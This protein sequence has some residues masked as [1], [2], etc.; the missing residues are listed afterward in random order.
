MSDVD[1]LKEG[2][3]PEDENFETFF[4]DNAYLTILFAPYQVA[5]YAAGPQTLRIPTSE[6]KDIL[7]S[8]Y[9]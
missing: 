7:R 6:L 2:T 5:S 3:S 9:Q 1:F 8:E 4:F